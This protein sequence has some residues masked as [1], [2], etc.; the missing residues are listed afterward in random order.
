[1]ICSTAHHYRSPCIRR[2][3]S[4]NLISRC[5]ITLPRA[6]ACFKHVLSAQP[7]RHAGSSL[8]GT[9]F[10]TCF[11]SLDVC[12]AATTPLVLEGLRL[13]ACELSR[14]QQLDPASYPDRSW[15]RWSSQWQTAQVGLFRDEMSQLQTAQVGAAKGDTRQWRIAQVGANKDETCQWRVAQVGAKKIKCVSGGWHRWA[16]LG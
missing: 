7:R 15:T 12:R 8:A 16:L 6:V 2:A 13:H 1:M 14:R 11:P 9:L 3:W 4:S 5:Q 10:L